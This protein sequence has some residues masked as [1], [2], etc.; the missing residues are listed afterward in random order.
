MSDNFCLGRL[1]CAAADY[2]VWQANYGSTAGAA[3]AGRDAA[4]EPAALALLLL[5]APACAARW[6]GQTHDALS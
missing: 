5:L 4:P 6:R 1:A 3:D 2:L